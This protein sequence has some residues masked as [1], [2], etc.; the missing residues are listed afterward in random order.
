MITLLTILVGL[1]MFATLAT[2]FA[3]MLGMSSGTSSPQRSNKLMRLRVVFQFV[4]LALFVL[5]LSLLHR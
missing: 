2:L 4:T 3:G 5:L 1:S